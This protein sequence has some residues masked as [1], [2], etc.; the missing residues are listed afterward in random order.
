[1]IKNTL[2]LI[3][4]LV[5]SAGCSFLGQNRSQQAGVKATEKIASDVTQTFQRSVRDTKPVQPQIPH[6]D[7]KVDGTNNTAT[8][9]LPDAPP[10]DA[11]MREEQFLV[12]S[13][14]VQNADSKENL[15]SSIVTK[16]PLWISLLGGA[17]GIFAIVWVIKYVRKMHPAIDQA[18]A[19][20]EDV[21]ARQIRKKR[22]QSASEQDANKRAAL[23][24][25]I[26]E[27]ESERGRMMRDD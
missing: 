12:S 26:A 4:C 21:L 1:M 7:I 24:A 19:Y 17:A 8:I 13:D 11:G 16:W 23:Q 18:W 25:E 20:G 22:E 14:T 10:R 9:K 3:L 2:P 15:W 6:I 5:L 27:L